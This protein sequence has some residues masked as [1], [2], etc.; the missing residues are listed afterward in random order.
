MLGLITISLN[1]SAALIASYEFNGNANDSSGND[2]HGFVNGATLTTDRFGNINQAYQ[3]DGN[4]SYI[5]TTISPISTAELTMS[6]WINPSN[7]GTDIYTIGGIVVNSGDYE[8]AITSEID[9]IRYAINNGSSFVW[10]DTGVSVLL[11][12]WSH[13]AIS[14]NGTSIATYINGIQVSNDPFSGSVLGTSWPFGIGARYLEQ[15]ETVPTT[16]WYSYFNGAIDDVSIYSHALTQSEI[17]TI[18]NSSS[19]PNP[20]V[21]WLLGIGLVILIRVRKNIQNY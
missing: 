18:V 8:F 1:V 21:L 11:N 14:Y 19:I 10:A 13:V 4:T 7:Q 9:T 20:S 3:F 12:Q 15:G 5:S 17:T 6:A 2:F 16:G